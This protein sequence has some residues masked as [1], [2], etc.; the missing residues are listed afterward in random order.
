MTGK[1]VAESNGWWMYRSCT[2]GGSFTQKFKHPEKPSVEIWVY[3]N[4]N[5]WVH[6]INKTNIKQGSIPELD[7]YLKTI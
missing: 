4:Q 6:R 2:C 7:A 5:K 3:P 1:Q